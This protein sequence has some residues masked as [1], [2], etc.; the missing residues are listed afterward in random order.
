M[1][2]NGSVLI[3]A[4]NIDKLNDDE[5]KDV[6]SQINI[7]I[8]REK[9]KQNIH[10]Q[11]IAFEELKGFRPQTIRLDQLIP[12]LI[13]NIRK[14]RNDVNSLV[15][16]LL[17]KHLDGEM[18]YDATV[19]YLTEGNIEELYQSYIKIFELNGIKSDPYNWIRILNQDG[20][21]KLPERQ[22]MIDPIKQELIDKAMQK[23]KEST[24]MPPKLAKLEDTIRKLEESHK[25]A[26]KKYELQVSQMK[27][28]NESILKE[29]K[30]GYGKYIDSMLDEVKKNLAFDYNVEIENVPNSR[31]KTI[32]ALWEILSN[33]ESNIVN[34]LN[35]TNSDDLRKILA[36][37]YA[38][39]LVGGKD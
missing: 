10:K 25:K 13:K 16:E 33:K 1:T 29:T 36:V 9:L 11:H 21:D 12:V 24:E 31:S 39:T 32:R 26:I 5:L 34:N 20:E 8:Y 19:K 15:T 28:E 2:K 17:I 30:L 22:E 18:F 37:K 23:F 4:R 35:R 6:L 3:I 14:K 7:N 38:L 27:A